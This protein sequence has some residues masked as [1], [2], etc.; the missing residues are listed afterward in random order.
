MNDIYFD[1]SNVRGFAEDLHFRMEREYKY[2]IAQIRALLNGG[3]G[4]QPADSTTES[5]MGNV[6]A[7]YYGRDIAQTQSENA[8]AA[9]DWLDS[10]Q[11]SLEALINAA[12]VTSENLDTADG[13]NAAKIDEYFEETT[14]EHPNLF[15][16]ISQNQII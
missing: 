7:E 8:L 3:D 13:E 14:A 6:D 5:P 15:P 16:G 9:A 10:L 12:L 4:N 2:E 1:V 11:T